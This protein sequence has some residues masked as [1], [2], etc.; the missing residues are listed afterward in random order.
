MKYCNFTAAFSKS[1]RCQSSV[2]KSTE[3][4]PGTCCAPSCTAFQSPLYSAP[5][6]HGS[7]DFAFPGSKE[8]ISASEVG[9]PSIVAPSDQEL[10]LLHR[11]TLSASTG[12]TSPALFYCGTS[13][14]MPCL[15]PLPLRNFIFH[16]HPLT[17][18]GTKLFLVAGRVHPSQKIS[19]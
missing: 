17:T 3:P 2:C 11:H 8:W 13:K 6:A 10:V 18:I 5:F 4:R 1:R 14:F 15:T 19:A 7:G 12:Q 9:I 16:T